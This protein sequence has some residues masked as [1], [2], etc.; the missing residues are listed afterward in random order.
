ME[1]ARTGRDDTLSRV[2]EVN[3]RLSRLWASRNRRTV[4]ETV[5]VQFAPDREDLDDGA[6][7]ALRTVVKELRG[8]ED[9]MVSVEGYTD[10]R[11]AR[12]RN[13]ELSR[14][15]ADAVRLYFVEQ[16]VDLLRIH[17]IGRGPL[18]DPAVPAAQKRRVTI[19]VIAPSE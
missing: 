3:T 18:T 2:D 9:L 16:G 19:K 1:P 5:H 17:A 11:G 10:V 14:R 6:R 7:T 12:E 4:I 8:N 13:L 15:R